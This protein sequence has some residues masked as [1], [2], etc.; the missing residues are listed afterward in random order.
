MPTFSHFI[1]I[2]KRYKNIEFHYVRL[3]TIFNSYEGYIETEDIEYGYNST[4]KLSISYLKSLC[5]Q[6]F[7]QKRHHNTELTS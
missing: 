4:S 3:C 2:S 6:F 5:H 1:F 7:D